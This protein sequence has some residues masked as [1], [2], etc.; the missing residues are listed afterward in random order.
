MDQRDGWNSKGGLR[1]QNAGDAKPE[2]KSEGRGR[3][4]RTKI[5]PE[6]CARTGWK[7]P[8][9]GKIP[10]SGACAEMVMGSYSC[11]EEAV[12]KGTTEYW[13]IEK[14][15]VPCRSKSSAVSRTRGQARS[16]FCLAPEQKGTRRKKSWEKFKRHVPRKARRPAKACGPSE[17]G[18]T[19]CTGPSRTH[20]G[21]SP[22]SQQ[23]SEGCGRFWAGKLQRNTQ[24]FT[25]FSYFTL[26]HKKLNDYG[27]ILK[28]YYTSLQCSGRTKQTSHPPPDRERQVYYTRDFAQQMTRSSQSNR[29]TPSPAP[30]F[31]FGPH[32]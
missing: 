17:K 28:T 7:N 19:K 29:Y 12:R 31:S 26:P 14:K 23:E 2:W 9:M 5:R 11:P 27:K 24:F 20:K 25:Y 13:V 8:G 32:H 18:S 3:M 21:K 10:G 22:Y 6:G 16:T 30:K 4:N 1:Q 15:D